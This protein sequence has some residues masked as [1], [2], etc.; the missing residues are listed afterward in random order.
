MTHSAKRDLWW[1]FFGRFQPESNAIK[2][3]SGK[4]GFSGHSFA[5]NKVCQNETS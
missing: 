1:H 2:L 5:P 4:L 3:Q